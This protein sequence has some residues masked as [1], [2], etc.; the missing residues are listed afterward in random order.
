MKIRY[1]GV[2]GTDKH[3]FRGESRQ[4]VGTPHER[5]LTEE[6]GRATGG[7]RVWTPGPT[8]GPADYG[9]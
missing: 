7:T 5:S 2:C 4:Y 8:A 3:T 9:R 6:S 1:S